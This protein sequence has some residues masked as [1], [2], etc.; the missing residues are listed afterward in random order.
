MEEVG[1]G[2]GALGPSGTIFHGLEHNPKSPRLV[3]RLGVLPCKRLPLMCDWPMWGD[4]QLPCGRSVLW[5]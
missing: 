4:T 3:H 5:A 1:S 2:F